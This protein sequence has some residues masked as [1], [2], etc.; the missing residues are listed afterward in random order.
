MHS[1][2]AT[3]IIVIV[4]A[5]WHLPLW[6]IPGSTGK[7]SF[8][9]FLIFLGFTL[10]NSFSLP[11]LYKITNSVL[12]CVLFHAWSNA[13]TNTFMPTGDLKTIAGFALEGIVSVILLIL[14][15]KGVIKTAKAR[16]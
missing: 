15:E 6:F 3:L 9:E 10:T 13:I 7:G 16:I 8:I 5:L 14:C 12:L 1:V 11:A 2:P 4:W